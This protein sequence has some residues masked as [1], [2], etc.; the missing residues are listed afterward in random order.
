MDS[1]NDVLSGGENHV[2]MPT[3]SSASQ[4]DEEARIVRWRISKSSRGA[5][6]LRKLFSHFIKAIVE[7]MIGFVRLPTIM[8]KLLA[9]NG[10]QEFGDFKL[11]ILGMLGIY[12]FE[13]R[14]L[15][16]YFLSSC[17]ASVVVCLY[18]SFVA[19]IHVS[20]I[21]LHLYRVLASLLSFNF[22]AESFGMIE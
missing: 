15:V 3:E 21:F 13:R 8:S 1:E 17:C 5:H 14:I 19:R 10:S 7:G 4:V 22:T 2:Q 20:R 18:V 9:D 6:I 16:C 12:G 11:T